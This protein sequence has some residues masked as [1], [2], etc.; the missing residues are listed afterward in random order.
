MTCWNNAKE[1]FVIAMFAWASDR[2][3]FLFW[4]D[5]GLM[6]FEAVLMASPLFTFIGVAAALKILGSLTGWRGGV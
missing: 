2:L 6:A 5:D 1:F 3:G 4:M